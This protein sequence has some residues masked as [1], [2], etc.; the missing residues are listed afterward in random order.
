MQNQQGQN[1]NQIANQQTGQLPK[2]KG[3]EMN[4]RDFLNDGLSTC[5]Y[6]TDSLNIAVREASHDQLHADLLQMLTETQQSCRDLFL[7]MFQNGWYKMEAEEQQKI[8]Q[9]YQQFSNYSSQFPYT[10]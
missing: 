5:K 1:P 6:I 7:V 2:V 8:N 4:D 9:A 10:H 3:P